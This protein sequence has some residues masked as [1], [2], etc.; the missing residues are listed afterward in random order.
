L[1]ENI[2]Q[3]RQ[4]KEI[5]FHTLK[6]KVKRKEKENKSSEKVMSI[7]HAPPRGRGAHT[8]P[9]SLATINFL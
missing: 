6:T 9:F 5:G 7:W 4:Q 8:A 3:D 2:K 1:K